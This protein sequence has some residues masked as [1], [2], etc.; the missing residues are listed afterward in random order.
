MKIL[1]WIIYGFAAIGFFLVAGYFAVR[2]GITNT[3]GIVD[4]Q[5]DSF[6]NR[7][8]VPLNRAWARGDEW[9]TFKE[10][11]IKDKA[12]IDRAAALSGVQSRLIVANLAVEQLRLFHSDRELFKLAFAPLK[13]LGNQSQFSWGVMGIKQETA[14]AIEANLTNPSSPFHL[15]TA[16]EK[17]LDF[18][19]DDA[20]SERFARLT[21]EKS[22]FY[23]YLYAGIY[24]KQIE[25]QWAK[26][27][28]DISQ[29]PEILATLFNIGFAHSQPKAEPQMGGAA[30]EINGATYSFGRIAGEFYYSDELLEQFP[31]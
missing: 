29:R 28:H 25:T 11:T 18:K 6:I 24:L 30:I 2:F 31:R 3:A 23:S 12:D 20:D 26:A 10:A 8:L 16:Q 7:D 19:T 15:G 22:R 14:R 1:N 21:D 5:R 9:N 4:N 17:A 27:G 13:M